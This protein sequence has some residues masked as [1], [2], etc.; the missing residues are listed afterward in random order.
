MEDRIVVEE[1]RG[2]EMNRRY[3]CGLR[4]SISLY[5]AISLI[6][7]C[8]MREVTKGAIIVNGESSVEREVWFVDQDREKVH[9]EC[10]I[11]SETINI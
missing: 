1:Y 7:G 6:S 4:G 11:V 2:G 3:D 5:M 8:S 9:Y 10:K